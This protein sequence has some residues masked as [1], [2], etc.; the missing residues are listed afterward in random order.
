LLQIGR[1][2]LEGRIFKL[3]L[4]LQA[5]VKVTAKLNLIDEHLSDLREM[6]KDH[7]DKRN[8]VVSEA[9]MARRQPSE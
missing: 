8:S 1:K 6:L 9:D 5:L 4:F 7:Q 3:D 2:T